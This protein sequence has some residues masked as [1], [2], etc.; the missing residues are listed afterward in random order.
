MDK[1]VKKSGD[2][3]AGMGQLMGVFAAGRGIGAV[4]SGPISEVLVKLGGFGG[5][6]GVLKGGYG[7]G[8]KFGVV[9]VFT[10]VSALCGVVALGVK[11]GKKN[12]GERG[13]GGDVNMD[14]EI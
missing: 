4:C 1:E 5:G 8:G 14:V 2:Q 6:K 12:G 9:I 11:R 7:Y 10:G 3:R 13:D